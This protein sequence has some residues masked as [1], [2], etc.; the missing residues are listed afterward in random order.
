MEEERVA[1]ELERA[2]GQGTENVMLGAML[3]SRGQMASEVR[4]GQGGQVRS[5][6]EKLP[7]DG[8]RGDESER[9]D[10]E[11]RT[12]P[13]SSV[14][15]PN[16]E[17]VAP[18]SCSKDGEDASSRMALIPPSVT[19]TAK[20]LG[21]VWYI[22]AHILTDEDFAAVSIILILLWGC[23]ELYWNRRWSREELA[24][25]RA[26]AEVEEGQ[27]QFNRAAAAAAAA[28]AAPAGE[29]LQSLCKVTPPLSFYPFPS[30]SHPPFLTPRIS[31]EAQLPK[32]F[33]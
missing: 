18:T 33:L 2:A 26:V 10:G 5:G 29:A 28:P 31:A 7:V 16:S 4:C 23:W 15:P 12:G 21:I 17:H 27:Q 20:V 14:S 9:K 13:S 32:C 6:G 1:G 25:T 11:E 8:V 19:L 3:R 24:V 30:H 22:V